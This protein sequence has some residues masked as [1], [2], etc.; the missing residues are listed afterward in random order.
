MPY[1]DQVFTLP[2]FEKYQEILSKLIESES[3]KIKIGR[4]PSQEIFIE[5]EDPI[6]YKNFLVLGSIQPPEENLFSLL[7]LTHTLKNNGASNIVAFIPYLAY[8]RQDHKEPL[9]SQAFKLIA[10][11]FKNSGIHEIVTVDI[12]SDLAKG[13]IPCNVKNL[14]SADL[15]IDCIKKNHLTFDSFLAPDMGAIERAQKLASLV[16]FEKKVAYIKKERTPDCVISHE[17]V[18]E[19][20]IKLAIVDDILDTGETLISAIKKL[21]K[22]DLR[23]I[24]IFVTHGIFSTEGWKELFTLGV[25]RIFIT[26]TIERSESWLDNNH[27]ESVSIFSLIHNYLKS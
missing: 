8:A 27:V 11:F 1:F 17:V 22:N 15:F 25:K 12:H 5:F 20:G 2:N 7:L 4:H 24:Y 18:G 23:E 19:V 6:H 21:P 3:E 9:K 13:L 16:G 14:S 26:N 10:S